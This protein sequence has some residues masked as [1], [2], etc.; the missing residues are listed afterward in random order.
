MD[1]FYAMM[2]LLRMK[3]ILNS[4]IVI[5]LRLLVNLKKNVI[6]VKYLLKR[7]KYKKHKKIYSNNK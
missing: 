4:Q 1:I 5:A 6:D 3:I 2:L 7:L